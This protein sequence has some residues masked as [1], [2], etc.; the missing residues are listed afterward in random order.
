MARTGSGT[1]AAA[2]LV[3]LSLAALFLAALATGLTTAPSAFAQT[4]AHWPRQCRADIGRTCRDVA[5]AEDK[6]ILL[7]LQENEAR[8]SQACRKLLQSYG[9][10]R[11]RQAAV[12]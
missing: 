12:S 10:V 6:A 3:V 1:G 8:L 9:H 7:C 2:F 11:A 5:K 4:L